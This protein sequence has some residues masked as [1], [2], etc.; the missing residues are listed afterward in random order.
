MSVWVVKFPQVGDS[1]DLI[2]R[3]DKV[4]CEVKNQIKKGPE[5]D[6]YTIDEY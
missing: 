4:M 1:I 5:N 2:K 3:A 6:F